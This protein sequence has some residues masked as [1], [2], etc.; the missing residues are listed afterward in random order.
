MWSYGVHNLSTGGLIA[1][2]FPSSV[3]WTRRLSG[4]GTGS[5]DFKLTDPAA[6]PAGDARD[7]FKPKDRA[8]SVRWNDEFVAY[9]GVVTK[10]VYDRS[11]GVLSVS[12][13]ELRSAVFRKRFTGRADN[14]GSSWNLNINT[15]VHDAVHAVVARSLGQGTGYGLPVLTYGDMTPPP[16]L[17]P[18][19]WLW[20]AYASVIPS[21]VDPTGYAIQI[22]CRAA[23]GDENDRAA[24]GPEVTVSA[25]QSVQYRVTA[26]PQDGADSDAA[27][28]VRWYGASGLIGTSTA[29]SL[30][31]AAG[32]QVVDTTV[33]APAGATSAR[34]RFI[35]GAGS[36]G[37]WYFREFDVRPV[38]T[39]G[40]VFT[41]EVRYW[42][43]VTVDSL[44]EEIEAQG[45][46]VDFSP[47]VTPE[48]RLVWVMVVAV[49]LDR[50]L[51][52]LSVDASE[53][54]ITG[55]SVTTDGAKQAT[56]V[57]A[58]GKGS[59]ADM[60]TG[61]DSS[62]AGTSA[63][64][65]KLDAKDTDRPADLQVAARE[66]LKVLVD[67]IEQ[68]SFSVRVGEDF[69]PWQVRPG[70]A[71][72]LSVF[73]DPFIPDGHRTKTVIALAG[74]ASLTVTPEVQ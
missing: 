9:A 44:L 69:S 46:L 8:V 43:T 52:S 12:T 16:S 68:W 31:V 34:A 20:G 57:L 56:A 21:T 35:V 25:G 55:L 5:F 30:T 23:T 13:D 4:T 42:E 33:T 18:S 61:Y 73:G 6:V 71:L 58:V 50:G 48:G 38:R 3:S 67:P 22:L 7:F 65:V 24:L 39:T 40:P 1:N 72:D 45:C 63:R 59:G 11:T 26:G 53:S 2:V 27:V 70:R 60:R 47:D 64:D 10:S 41:R 51:T 17:V 28:E 66:E 14:Y 49:N 15:R 29:Q 74:D 54:R 32:V 19:S 37:S 62:T 36:A